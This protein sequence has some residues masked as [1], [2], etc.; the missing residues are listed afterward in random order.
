MKSV[1]VDEGADAYLAG[2]ERQACPYQSETQDRIDWVRGWDEA[3]ESDLLEL[4]DSIIC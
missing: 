2:T 3:E 1:A 4:A